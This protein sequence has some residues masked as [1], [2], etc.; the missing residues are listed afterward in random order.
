MPC[1]CCCPSVWHARF[2]IATGRIAG[3]GSQQSSAAG[4]EIEARRH[5]WREDERLRT[6]ERSRYSMRRAR[7]AV[8]HA[9]FAIARLLLADAPVRTACATA[10]ACTTAAATACATAAAGAHA[11]VATLRVRLQGLRQIVP[12]VADCTT[13]YTDGIAGCVASGSHRRPRDAIHAQARA[14]L[15][16]LLLFASSLLQRQRFLSDTQQSARAGLASDEDAPEKKWRGAEGVVGHLRLRETSGGPVLCHRWIS[17]GMS[18]AS[19]TASHARTRA[20]RAARAEFVPSASDRVRPPSSA[21]ATTGPEPAE[22]PL[23]T[24][25][26]T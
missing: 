17:N 9:L 15:R 5:L 3:A 4:I 25:S 16:A 24:A 1:A 20:R 23:D 2:A 19:S 11:A 8:E 22:L 12:G 7:C 6:R 13:S 14:T 10:A 18:V 21:P 26:L